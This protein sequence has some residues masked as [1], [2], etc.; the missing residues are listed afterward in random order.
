MSYCFDT[1]QEI[2]SA[3]EKN[4]RALFYGMIM[5]ADRITDRLQITTE[6][7]FV[8]NL[9]EELC[10]GLFEQH[11]LV[12][13]N[14]NSYT[15]TLLGD[16]FER[17]CSEFHID[18]HAVQPHLDVEFAENTDEVSAFLKGAFLVGGSIANPQSAYHLELI[19]HHYHLSKE[20]LS[21]LKRADFA[22]KS[23]VR[24]SQYV[25]YLKDS[26]VIERFLYVLGAKKAA[27]ALVDAKIYKQL[28]NDD[29]RLNNCA[30]YN[31]DKMMDKAIHQLLAIRKIQEKMG[32]ASLPEDLQEIAQLRLDHQMASLSELCRLTEG[33]FSKAGLSRR[34]TKIIEIANKIDG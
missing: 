1:K 19:C 11:F 7:V 6:N 21:F 13:E 31:R 24:K 23:V 30:E 18:P 4:K 27:F 5:F 9:L 17:V 15:A 29:N 34:L 33:K 3:E 22:F 8:I 32:L 10:F 14:G 20:I 25:L 26:V 2:C 12:D 16:S 28:Q